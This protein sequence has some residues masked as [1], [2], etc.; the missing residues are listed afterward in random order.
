MD[1]MGRQKTTVGIAIVH[2]VVI[3]TITTLDILEVPVWIEASIGGVIDV[4]DQKAESVV[5]GTIKVVEAVVGVEVKVKV[6]ES[7]VV[8]NIFERMDMV[9]MSKKV[10]TLIT[11]M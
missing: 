4:N 2:K 1:I 10:L 11:M 7:V 8:V 5:R 9:I 3:T 6:R